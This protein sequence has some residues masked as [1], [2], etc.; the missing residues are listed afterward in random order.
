MAIS[1]NILTGEY[2][3]QAGGVSDYTY[4]IAAALAAQGDCVD[5]WAPPCE[6]S[7]PQENGARMHRLPDHFRKIG[8]AQIETHLRE[9]PG[10]RLLVQYVPHAFG[11]RG[12]NVRFCLWVRRMARAGIPV[13]VMFHEV[14]YPRDPGQPLKHRVLALVTRQMARW[15]SHCADRIFVSI[16]GWGD[17]LR[18]LGVHKR[19]RWLPVPSNIVQSADPAGVRGVRGQFGPGPL[20]GHFGTYGALVLIELRPVIL[21]LL[22]RDTSRSLLLLGRGSDAFANELCRAE[23]SL[24]DRVRGTGALDAPSLAEHL[25]ACDLLVQPYP[26]GI[27]CRRS[28]AMAGLALGVPVVSS[29]GHLTESIWAESGAVA[30]ARDTTPAALAAAAEA[31]LANKAQLAELG[32]RGA[33]LYRDRFD[34]RATIGELRTGIDGGSALAKTID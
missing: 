6:G 26:D 11:M 33:R 15:T 22:K 3:P 2:P 13:D 34:L 14:A 16:L 20:I 10:S 30:L 17:L 1:W 24:G 29:V 12:M 31:A 8:L 19:T 27:S 5:V 9:H 4:Q 21:D 7:P 28:S 23:P 32:I 25:S 18:E